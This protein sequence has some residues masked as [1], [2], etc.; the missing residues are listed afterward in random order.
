M[1]RLIAAIVACGLAWAIGLA[2]VVWVATFLLA[3]GG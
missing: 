1:A 2:I 3:R